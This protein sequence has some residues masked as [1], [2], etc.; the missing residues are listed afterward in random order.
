MKR[1]SRLLALLLC[2]LLVLT[3]LA[4]C[5][6]QSMDTSATSD[7]VAYDNAAS[8][9][10]YEGGESYPETAPTEENTATTD[11]AAS[12]TGLTGSGIQISVPDGGDISDKLIYTADVSIE[13]T[14]FD[15]ATTKVEGITTG[16]GG[17]LESSN[18]SGNTY[19]DANGYARTVDRYATYTLR[20]PSENFKD[21][22]EALQTIGSVTSA[23]TNVQDVTTQYTDL[24]ARKTSLETQEQRLLELLEQ[25]PD[26]ETLVT[27]ESRLSEVRYEIESIEQNLRGLDRDIAYS[28]IYLDL[29]EVAVYTPTVTVQRTFGERLADSLSNGWQGF[30]NFC[31]SLVLFLASSW[32]TLVLLAVIVVVVVVVIR[33]KRRARNAPVLKQEETSDETSDK[34]P[35][36]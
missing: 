10:A 18:I 24:E 5:A 35:R 23:N 6:A 34:T 1:H 17:Y 4:G 36:E 29:R 26:V 20:I 21:A 8:S 32:P 12:G 33:R 7:S 11:E 16:R 13:T 9:P 2:L 30:V 19:Y 28:T 15:V 25:S 14:Q 31:K 27:L 3:A 22:L